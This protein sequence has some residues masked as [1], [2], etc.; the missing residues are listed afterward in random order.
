MCLSKDNDAR[1]LTVPYPLVLV[2]HLMLCIC[3][4]LGILMSTIGAQ[5]V[6]LK[7]NVRLVKFT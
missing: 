2:L 1:Y 7:R 5:V 4:M 3:S 6:I